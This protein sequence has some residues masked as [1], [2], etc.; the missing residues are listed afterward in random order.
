MRPG[1]QIGSLKPTQPKDGH[2][3]DDKDRSTPGE[4]NFDKPENI[5]E[6]VKA[7]KSTTHIASQSTGHAARY[8]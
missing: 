4:F 1:Q 8:I 5:L 7:S 6:Q 3:A 2:A